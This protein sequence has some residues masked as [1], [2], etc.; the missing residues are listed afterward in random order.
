ML[1]GGIILVALLLD[2]L[3]QYLGGD[4]APAAGFAPEFA[5]IENLVATGTDLPDAFAAR[6]QAITDALGVPVNLYNL[7]AFAGLDAEA[8]R[9]GVIDVGS[10]SVR[11]VV[12]EGGRRIFK[13]D[14]QR[15]GGYGDE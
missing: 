11:L 13:G 2:L 6:Q 9:I 15:R 5:L 14:Y 7:N 1:A 8:E 10:N 12:Y 4:E 3:L